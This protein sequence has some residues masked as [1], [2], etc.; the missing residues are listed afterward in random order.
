M[1]RARKFTAGKV[2]DLHDDFA[3][4]GLDAH[5]QIPHVHRAALILDGNIAVFVGRCPAD[6]RDIKFRDR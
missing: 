2:F 1:G 6:D 3:A 4:A 5:G